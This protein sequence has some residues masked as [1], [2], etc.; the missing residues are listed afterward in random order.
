MIPVSGMNVDFQITLDTI[1]QFSNFRTFSMTRYRAAGIHLL[2][3]ALIAGSAIVATILIMYPS[4]YS[5]AA[6][7][8]R[9]LYILLG[10]DIV[11]GPLITLLIFRQG[12]KG[13]KFDL[14][15]IALLQVAALVY[16]LSVITKARPVFLVFLVDRFSLVP[17]QAIQD[18]H[19][20][21]A[22]RPEFSKLSWT[23]PVL[24]GAKLPEDSEA[25]EEVLWRSL[26]E[27]VDANWRPVFYLPIE[28]VKLEMCQAGWSINEALT[29]VGG[30]KALYETW[31]KETEQPCEHCRAYPLEVPNNA[32]TLLF[33]CEKLE[34]MG[35]INLDP[36]EGVEG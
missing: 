19:L 20:E 9:L 16:G 6:G 31:S 27:G 34:V 11:L 8:D 17:A 35:I 2:I 23:G 36:W 14:W 1:G 32:N 5:K 24:A 33:D 26:S 18:F 22:L 28:D 4:P 25:R 30:F 21:Q 13:L 10:V 29:E 3:S 15:V 12:K 7:A